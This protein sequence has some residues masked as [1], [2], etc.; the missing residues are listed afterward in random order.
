MHLL[1]KLADDT[2]T[3]LNNIILL[4]LH[5]VA[6]LSILRSFDA[7]LRLVTT[8]KRCLLQ[9]HSRLFLI[10]W[11]DV[12]QGPAAIR[13]KFANVHRLIAIGFDR[14]GASTRDLGCIPSS[15]VWLDYHLTWR[16]LLRSTDFWWSLRHN[17]LTAL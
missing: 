9:S 14:V 7:H 11:H 1:V 2:N 16:A 12:L 5:C 17:G 10:V 8:Y 15:V 6:N 4:L 13:L 3:S